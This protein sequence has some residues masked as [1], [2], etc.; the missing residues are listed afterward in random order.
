MKVSIFTPTHDPKYLGE[1]AQSIKS[2]TYKDW[3]WIIVPNGKLIK[4]EVLS[5]VNIPKDSRIKVILYP[6]NRTNGGKLKELNIG[7]LKKFACSHCSGDI[8]AEV[9]HDD[10]LVPTCLEKVVKAFEKPHI[11]FVYSDNAKLGKFTPYKNDWVSKEFDWNGQKLITM[12]SQPLTP[13]RLGYIWYAPDHIRVWRKSAYDAAGGY[14]EK[15]SV[16]DD[17]DL[18][19]RTYMI[20]KF[21]HIPETLY[22]YRIREDKENTWLKRNQAI[23]TGTRKMYLE[24]I[25]NLAVRYA[26]LNG[27]MKIDLCGGFQKPVG[28]ISIDQQGGDITADLNKGIP[29]ADNS[30]GVLRA[31]DALEHLKDKQRTMAEI[32]RVLAPGGILLSCTPSTDGRGAWQDPTHVSFWN[33]NSFWYYTRPQQMQFINNT[34]LKFR[35]CC[36]Q[37]TALNK[38]NQD[39]K[40]LHVTAHLEKL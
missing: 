25:H 33:E 13:G 24:H 28:F 7:A 21:Y 35:E 32:H 4:K 18:M 14:D 37:T 17:L 31:F 40:I 1:L 19:H 38:F 20:T 6:K 34:D 10:I 11:G 15:L 30:V 5:I 27:L 23:Q 16:L 12:K 9:D 2:Q 26:D 36:L 39:N 22:I 29:L 8:L 3:E